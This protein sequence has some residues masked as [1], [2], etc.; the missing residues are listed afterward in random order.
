MA[1]VR[2]Y[3]NDKISKAAAY[4]SILAA[5][6]ESEDYEEAPQNQLEAAIGTYLTML[7]QHDDARK[8][9]ARRGRGLRSE[10]DEDSDEE[11]QEQQRS[12]RRR[13]DSPEASQAI[14]KRKKVPDETLF[15]W[16]GTDSTSDV[17]LTPSQELTRKLVQN[18]TIDIKAT[19]RRVLSAKRVPEFP[20]SEWNNVL[21]G[22]AVNLDITF[23][24]MYSTDSDNRAVENIGDLELHFGASKPAKTVETHGDWVIA[25]RIAFRATRFIFPHRETELDDYNDYITSYFASIHPSAHWKVL[26]LDKAI[27]NLVGAVNDVSL[28]EFAKFRYLETRYLHGHGTGESSTLPKDKSGGPSSGWRKPDPCRLWNEG[29]CNHQASTC[30]FRHICEGCRGSHRKTSCPREKSAEA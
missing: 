7:D 16:L 24:G 4:A 10:N 6:T 3:G 19:K 21:A 22:K 27:R 23:S 28:N 25:W 12:K 5:I 20:D 30:K 1:T 14:S 9:T 11:H 15:A 8:D 26:N 13:S 29:K 18:H 2:D 17:L